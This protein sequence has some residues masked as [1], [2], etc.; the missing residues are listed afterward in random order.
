M[1]DLA[2]D[3]QPM[4][5]SLGLPAGMGP[6]ANPAPPTPPVPA[7]APP[8]VVATPNPAAAAQAAHETMLGKTVKALLGQQVDYRVDPS[9]G[10][11]QQVPME[12]KPGG[13][14]RGILAG[15][16]LGASA[17]ARVPRGYDGGPNI[18][19]SVGA[20]GAASIEDARGQ[21]AQRMQR[22][23]QQFKNQNEAQDEQRKQSGFDTEQQMRKAQTALV[24]MQTVRENQVIQGANFDQH[25]KVGES[26]KV[27]L[28]PYIEAGI[29]L[30]YKDI[31]ESQMND[32]LSKNSGL[33]TDY[34]WE[35]TGTKIVQDDQ[36]NPHYE[37]TYS[38]VKVG[39]KV[40]M[41]PDFIKLMKDAG[42]EKYYPNLKDVLKPGQQLDP[43]AFLVLKHQLTDLTNTNME[44]AKSTA[45][46]AHV[47][48]ETNQANASAAHLASEMSR[49][50]KEDKANEG[51]QS[52]L[53]SLDTAGGD[54]SKLAPSERLMIGEHTSKLVQGFN[55]AI[56]DA[57]TN[58]QDASELMKQREQVLSLSTQALSGGRAAAPPPKPPAPNTV[59][60]A[61]VVQSY[62]AAAGGDKD[63]ARAAAAADGWAIPGSQPSAP[64][65]PARTGSIGTAHR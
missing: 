50:N 62:I 47:R 15:A 4:S 11:T 20:G 46:L 14:F 33:S 58:G 32:L 10:E 37:S 22:A 64:L 12:E 34:D 1:P 29:P 13:L 39:S 42:M 21:D 65:V 35:P 9:T 38:A 45:M 36:G 40:T 5:E 59:I 54:V 6:I 3:A 2:P 55:V 16:L 43:Q 51:F 41:T 53:K 57:L 28:A 63:K 24:N 25:E 7:P 60:T 18:A 31:P 26:G 61:D 52:A 30:A 19:A 8:P 56:R 48:A 27:K 23:Q 44:Q 49:A 17:S